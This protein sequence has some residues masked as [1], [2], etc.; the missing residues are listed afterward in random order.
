M[1][2]WAKGDKSL[3]AATTAVVCILVVMS[4]YYISMPCQIPTIFGL[5]G[6]ARVLEIKIHDMTYGFIR[7]PSLRRF[8]EAAREAANTLSSQR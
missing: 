8:K 2:T 3:R 5:D 1:G 7:H 4:S 6:L